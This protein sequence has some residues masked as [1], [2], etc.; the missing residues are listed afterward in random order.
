MANIRCPR[1]KARAGIAIFRGY[2]APDSM[3][4]LLE[5]SRKGEVYLGGCLVSGDGPDWHCRACG[6]E[7]K[8]PPGRDPAR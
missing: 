2:P 3:D 8:D 4:D 1:C 7:W 6:H 5:A